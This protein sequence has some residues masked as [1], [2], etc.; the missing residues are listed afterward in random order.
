[1][2]LVTVFSFTSYAQEVDLNTSVQAGFG[3]DGDVQRDTLYFTN[4]GLVTWQVGDPINM[5]TGT[6][7]WF[8][9]APD[10][11][12]P[13]GTAHQGAGVIDTTDTAKLAILQSGSNDTIQLRM[14]SDIYTMPEGDGRLWI[15]AVYYRDQR[16]DGSNSDVTVFDQKVNKNY[17]NPTRWTLKDGEVPQKNDLI[18]V[19]AHLRRE[20]NAG[21]EYAIV[22]ASTRN[23]DGDSYLDFEYYREKITLAQDGSSFI[24]EGNECGHSA[25]EF[26]LEGDGSVISHGDI[27]LSVNY[28]KG[29][30]VVDIR[31]LV[32]IDKRD[33]PTNND[34]AAFNELSGRPFNF[35]T[36]SGNFI[37]YPCDNDLSNNYG[38]ARIS[39]KNGQNEQMAVF[40]QSN[41]GG[42]VPAPL[43]G[44]IND[45]GDLV[46]FYQ[47]NT[48]AELALNATLFGFDTRSSQSLCESPLGSVIV[49]S[50][51][52]QSFDSS[53]KDFAG[54][55]SLGDTPEVTVSV[56]DGSYECFEESTTL[57]AIATP[58]DQTFEYQ[59][60]ELVDGEYVEID[61]ATSAVLENVTVGTYKV[62]ATIQIAGRAGCTAE[63]EGIAV[64]QNDPAEI[65]EVS[66]SENLDL[67]ACTSTED[68]SAA[69][70]AWLNGGTYNGVTYSGFTYSGGGGEVSVVY[71]AGG[72]E[73]SS[74]DQIEFDGDSCDGGSITV[75]ISVTDECDQSANCNATFSLPPDETDPT[76]DTEAMDET[77]ECDGEGNM[78]ALQAWLDNNGGAMASDSCGDVTW[79]NDFDA[80]SDLCGATGSATVTFTATDDCGNTSETS[81]TFTIEDTTDPMIDTEA[82]DE[83]VE[84]DGQGNT[85]ALDA[86]LAN[87]GGAMA[88]D[89]C[90]D[91]TWS[92][93]FDALSDL[94]GATGSA[95]VTFT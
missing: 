32:W 91:V 78:A 20:P 80:L 60:Y 27:I 55:F 43:W 38:Y 79:S 10:G 47:T 46:D 18:D 15:D 76:I 57:T 19:F 39:L 67:E 88:S 87:N 70:E 65:L 72:N 26:D 5:A 92:N 12:G 58:Q 51:S 22:A 84:C 56:A 4:S 53:L 95:T 25:Y 44:T 9:K 37:F 82:M 63:A 24:T 31:L 14:S 48:F 30:D 42:P 86:W 50:R 21:D 36:R 54:P 75:G 13:D 62:S 16:T 17:N 49:K 68:V 83:T 29:G 89:S 34:F 41:S 94:C 28:T 81:A 59:W 11:T 77:V 93:D 7:D 8:H 40:A 90:G 69:F 35:G 3:I 73:Y 74:L 61:G 6:D 2:L 64:V 71:T 52:S 1:M 23:S 33:F 66:C 45:A 85:A